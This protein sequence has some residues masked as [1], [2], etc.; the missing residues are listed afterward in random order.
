MADASSARTDPAG[1]ALTQAEQAY[2]SIKDAILRGELATGTQML[3]PAL[4]LKLGMSRT[5]VHEALVR[6]QDEGYVE[7]QP[8]RGMRVAPMSARDIREITELLACLEVE[9]AERTA[10]R[11]LPAEALAAFDA[12]IEA[13]DRALE[14]GDIDAWNRADYAFHLLLIESC[15]NRHL[16]ETAR[17]FLE[18]AHR[19]RFLT[20]RHRKPPVYSNVNHAAVVEAIR[21]GDPQSAV[22]IHRAHKRRWLRE[23]DDILAHLELEDRS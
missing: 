10:T 19:Y 16:I 20:S 7:L 11:R 4:A 8:R 15:G 1:D 22:E 5:P 14:A 13:M 23:L 21:R 2:R 9:A 3:E 17:R 18:K 6:L 12:A